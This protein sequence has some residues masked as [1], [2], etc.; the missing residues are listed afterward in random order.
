MDVGET[1]IGDLISFW[2]I[3]K[4]CRNDHLDLIQIRI[5]FYGAT[6][7]ETIH[8]RHVDIHEQ[9]V[10]LELAGEIAI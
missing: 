7:F 4:S 1:Q 9:D 10:G 3:G 5:S 2:V 6:Y 8:V